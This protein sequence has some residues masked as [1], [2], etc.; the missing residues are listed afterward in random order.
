[1]PQHEFGLDVVALVGALR[2]A[3]HRSVTEIH[4]ELVRRGVPICVRG[5]SNLLDRYDELLASSCSDAGR[6]R[7]VTAKGEAALP[8]YEADRHA[9]VQLKKKVRGTRPIER[10][11]EGRVDPEAEKIRGDCAGVRS[12]LTDD[13]RPPLTRSGLKLADRLAAVAS[14]LDRVAGTRGFRRN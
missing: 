1:M 7:R 12:S 4:T 9:K 10:K 14:S 13:G 5:V 3:E 11:V 8:V 6:L 2:H